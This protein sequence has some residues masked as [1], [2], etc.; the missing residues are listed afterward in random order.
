MGPMYFFFN[1]YLR[2]NYYV[3]D[4]IAIVQ[5]FCRTNSRCTPV[6]NYIRDKMLVIQELLR[7][8]SP[9]DSNASGLHF[10]TSLF[11]ST[12]VNSIR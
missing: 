10:F 8:M 7:M 9:V 12:R 1:S 11:S 2:F 4:N 5:R 6:Q 3:G